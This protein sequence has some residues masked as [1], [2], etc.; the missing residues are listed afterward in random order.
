MGL[1]LPKVEIW[2]KKFTYILL[3][4]ELH[5]NFAGIF[6]PIK[7]LY[8]LHLPMQVPYILTFTFWVLLPDFKNVC[9]C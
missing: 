8:C 9:V 5:S 4:T 2:L 7:R 1:K 6:N 3:Q